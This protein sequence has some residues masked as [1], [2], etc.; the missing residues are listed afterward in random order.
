MTFGN[1][2]FMGLSHTVSRIFAQ[3]DARIMFQPAILPLWECKP[4]DEVVP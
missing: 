1:A 3:A 4:M 2:A